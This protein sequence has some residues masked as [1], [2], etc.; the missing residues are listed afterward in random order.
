MVGGGAVDPQ[1]CDGDLPRRAD[2]DARGRQ[3][4]S[5][6]LSE[7]SRLLWRFEHGT[8]AD[9]DCTDRADPKVQGDHAHLNLETG[10]RRL[11]REETM[12]GPTIGTI[13]FVIIVAA[14]LVAIGVWLMN[15]LY[16][17]SSKE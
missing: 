13:I 6:E 15:W 9:R 11:G 5:E 17:R 4:H 3:L 2:L 16:R 14:I 12:S 8:L 1:G 7:L 10:R